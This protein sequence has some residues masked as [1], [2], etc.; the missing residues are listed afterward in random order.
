MLS[1]ICKLREHSCTQRPLKSANADSRIFN[2]PI[3]TII[4]NMIPAEQFGSGSG[5][6]SSGGSGGGGGSS[7][8]ST[9]F[10]AAAAIEF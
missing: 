8:S 10:A 9:K 1:G 6:S 2:G 7:S 3:A 4:P 5:S